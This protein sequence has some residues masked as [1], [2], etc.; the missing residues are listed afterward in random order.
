[1]IINKKKLQDR[2]AGINVNGDQYMGDAYAQNRQI[3]FYDE[4]PHDVIG[5]YEF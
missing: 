5:I 4:A 3:S 2:E 1:M